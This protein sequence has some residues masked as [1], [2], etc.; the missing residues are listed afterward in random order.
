[1]VALAFLLLRLAIRRQ[2]FGA[3]GIDDYFLILAVACL[4]GDCGIQQY[5]WNEGRVAHALYSN[6]PDNCDIGV[7]SI[8]TASQ[9]NFVHIMQVRIVGFLE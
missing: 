6:G 7:A 4:I 3:L 1:M 5:M 2:K 8:P 9:E